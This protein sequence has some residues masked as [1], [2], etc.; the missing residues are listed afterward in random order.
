MGRIQDV[1][2]VFVQQIDLIEVTNIIVA[3]TDGAMAVSS[4]RLQ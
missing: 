4:L 1:R 3:A 2:S